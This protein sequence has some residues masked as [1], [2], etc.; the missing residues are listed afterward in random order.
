MTIREEFKSDPRWNDKNFKACLFLVE[1][2]IVPRYLYKFCKVDDDLIDN[3]RNNQLWFSSSKDFND[4]FDCKIKLANNMNPEEIEELAN[5]LVEL[6]IVNKNDRF[7]IVYVLKNDHEK[8]LAL[9]DINIREQ[10]EKY[11]ICCFSKERNYIPM[12]SHYADKHQ[13][14]CLKF[15]VLEDTDIFFANGSKPIDL[16]SSVEYCN[17]YPKFNAYNII[18]EDGV[19]KQLFLIKSNDWIYEKEFRIMSTRKGGM[20]FNKKSLKEVIFGCRI[21][22]IKKIKSKLIKTI[23]KA[24]YPN[25]KFYNAKTSKEK[26]ELT[27][28]EI[29]I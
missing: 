7:K 17:D 26:F 18:V 19:A 13:G 9:V 16:I 23:K 10:F 8:S 20:P 6:R 21:D 2:K 29:H 4:P 24:N 27:F 25:I 3:L 28:E 5:K 14:I 15:D 11:G 1:S 22:E 12:W